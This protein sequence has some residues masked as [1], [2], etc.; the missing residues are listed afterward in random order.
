MNHQEHGATS[1]LLV[2]VVVKSNTHRLLRSFSVTE[3]FEP[4]GQ[5]IHFAQM[6]VQAR[7]A[8]E[9]TWREI[10]GTDRVNFDPLHSIFSLAKTRRLVGASGW[11]N[12]RDTSCLGRLC[13][14]C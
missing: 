4:G 3:D 14:V 13:R 7:T 10:E 5:P 8:V 6:D 12:V 2:H 1:H 11:D 9:N